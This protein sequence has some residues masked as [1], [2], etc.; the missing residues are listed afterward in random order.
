M[1]ILLCGS[2]KF[3]GVGFSFNRALRQLGHEV[4][5]VD[6]QDFFGGLSRSFWPKLAY[7]ILGRRPLTYWTYNRHLRRVAC[8]FRPQLV[9][10]TKGMF[11]RP[12]TLGLIKI[13]T[14]ATLINYA[15]DDPFNPVVSTSDMRAAIPLY[16]LYATTKRANIEDLRQAGCRNPVYVGFGYDPELHFPESPMPDEAH[17][18]A[19]D[20]VF[21][22][23]CDADRVPFFEALA[24]LPHLNLRLYGGYW[25]RHRKLR[26]YWRGFAVGR[27]YRLALCSSKIAP[28]LVRRANRD[29]HVMRT[30][31]I[32]ACGVFMLAERTEEHL[33]LFEEDKEAAYFSSPQELVDKVRYYLAHDEERQRIA[34]AGYR[35]V[36]SGKHTYK[37]RLVEIMRMV[38]A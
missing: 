36:T 5:F 15:T 10:V 16:D 18:W 30:F 24:Q 1:R 33:E 27:E 8:S 32:P 9:L 7:R 28:C 23:G 3:Y 29:A 37:D 34:G 11:V 31:E 2:S 4:H 22:G 25:N 20:V 6:E 38:T 21:I 17:C 19:S 26:S 13:E 35:R 14:G 12:D